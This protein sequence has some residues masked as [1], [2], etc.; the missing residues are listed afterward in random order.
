MSVLYANEFYE[1][2]LNNK[3][4]FY[5]WNNKQRTNNYVSFVLYQI[6]EKQI[7]FNLIN[8]NFIQKQI[9]CVFYIHHY[10]L[11][12][13]NVDSNLLMLIQWRKNTI[14]TTDEGDL[15]RSVFFIFLDSRPTQNKPF[16]YYYIQRI[17]FFNSY[18]QNTF[19]I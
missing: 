13:I 11:F 15:L 1:L 14:P 10:I 16:H 17:S 7:V 9:S 18:K 5:C 8:I 12:F 4:F 2:I 3:S 6:K 19:N